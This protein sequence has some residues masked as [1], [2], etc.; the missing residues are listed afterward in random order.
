M[1]YA[2]FSGGDLLASAGVAK[3]RW[4]APCSPARRPAPLQASGMPAAAA[5]RNSRRSMALILEKQHINGLDRDAN[6]VAH[7]QVHLVERVERHDRLQE[8][9]AGDPHAGLA[10]HRA[11]FD[12]D[13]FTFQPIART[14]LHAGPP[15]GRTECH[16]CAASPCRSAM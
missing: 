8:R 12:F 5:A 10:H 3:V 1:T 11:A 7:L 9:S 6:L 2:S 16:F 4:S 14:D 15:P 13:H